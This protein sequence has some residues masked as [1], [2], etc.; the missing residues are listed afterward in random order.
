MSLRSVAHEARSALA[1]SSGRA[2]VHASGRGAAAVSLTRLAR[3]DELVVVAANLARQLG[4]ALAEPGLDR[5]E[6]A[7]AEELLE[8]AVPIVGPGP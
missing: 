4:P 1:S 5:L 6:A 8:Q 7:G 3:P 2:S